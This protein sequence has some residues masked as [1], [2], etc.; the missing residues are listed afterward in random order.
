M[1]AELRDARERYRRLVENVPGIVYT[2]DVSDREGSRSFSYIS[3]QVEDV[4]GFAPA[5]WNVSARLH[6]HDRARVR[7][8]IAR[9]ARTGEALALEYRYLAQ[10]GRVVWVLDQASLIARS[11]RASPATFQ[12]VMLDITAL[13]DAQSKA[14][15]AEDRFRALTETGPVVAYAY[16]LR[17]E[18]D[19]WPPPIELTYMSP[20][21][22]EVVGFSSEELIVEPTLWRSLIHPD[23]RDATVAE[24]ERSWR[25]GEDWDVRYRIIRR[26]GAVVWLRSFGWMLARDE[27]GRPWRFQGVLFDITEEQDQLERLTRA[28]EGQ[29]TAL[30]GVRA[31]PWTETIDPESGFERYTYI[32]PQVAELLGYTPEELMVERKHFPR[33]LYRDDRARIRRSTKR[34]ALTGLW[35]AE[36]RVVARD[37]RIRWL[38]SFARRSSPPGT[39]PELWHGVTVDVT[40]SRAHV[41]DRHEV[42]ERASVEDPGRS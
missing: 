29:R 4:L 19:V 25:T 31:I 39:T 8:A 23:D 35:E 26:D 33:M 16:D 10:D 41:E 24:F 37:G 2:W 36:Y 18:P 14:E 9:S 42:A 13:K 27:A 15:Q 22:A 30:E 38:H 40:S 5:G 32:G 34:A 3:P 28:E 21:M 17:R 6:P 12:G 1:E 11:E 7:D 20:Q